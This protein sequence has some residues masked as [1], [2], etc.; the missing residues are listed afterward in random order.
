VPTGPGYISGWPFCPCRCFAPSW[1][2][3]SGLGFAIPD[4]LPF[5]SQNTVLAAQP[6]SLAVIDTREFKTF[7][8]KAT[9]ESRHL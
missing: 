4:Q 8:V 7:R 6:E 3:E 1:F 9:A 5:P 2:G